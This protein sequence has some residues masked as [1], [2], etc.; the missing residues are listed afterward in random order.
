MAAVVAIVGPTGS[1]KTEVS[2][3]LAEL[4]DAEIVNCDSRQVYR[5]LDIGS[6]KP[7][8]TQRRAVAHHVFDVVDPD[9]R[10]DCARYRDL[11][12]AAIEDI[13]TRG[14]AVV[15]VGGTGL[16]LKVL[17]FGLFP[18]PPRDDEVRARLES[19]ERAEPGVLHRRLAEVD[20]VSADR[21]HPNDR[22][23]IVRALEVMELT[24]GAIS[25]WQAAHGFRNDELGVRVFGIDV[26]RSELYRRL[27]GRCRAM[28]EQGLIQEVVGLRAAGFGRSSALQSIGYREIG[29][30]LDG[31]IGID[32]ALR[33]MAQA[34]RRF[35]KRQITWFRGDSGVHW[36]DAGANAAADELARRILMEMGK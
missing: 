20:P 17:R 31:G 7:S 30:H 24:G 22:I 1:G 27:D 16:Y 3:A 10:F 26:A 33:R 36:L 34:T 13:R 32:E 11:A 21:I 23:R 35:A 14:K 12:L 5:G 2:L 18:G 4:L 29:E 9:Q 15:L 28:V 19:N 25:R 8:L 6:A